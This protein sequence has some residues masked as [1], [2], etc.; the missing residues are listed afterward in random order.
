MR[1]AVDKVAMPVLVFLLSVSLHKC[2]I[3]VPHCLHLHVALTGRTKDR[4]LGTFQKAMLFWL[5]GIENYFVWGFKWLSAVLSNCILHNYMCFGHSPL[6]ITLS[7]SF[8]SAD[9][10]V[11]LHV[12][13]SSIATIQK[14]HDSAHL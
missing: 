5:S 6:H 3:S 7:M 8:R 12:Q 14:T 4:G 1:F 11:N 10:S 13:H 9:C 2:Y